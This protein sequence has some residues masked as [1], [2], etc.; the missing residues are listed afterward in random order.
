MS[1]SLDGV[2]LHSHGSRLMG[3]FFRAQA[4]EPRPTALLLHGIPGVEKNYDLA[5]ALRD[6][7]WNVLTFHYR[8][9]WGSEGEYTLPGIVDDIIVAIDYL[10]ERADVDKRR[11][12]GVGLSLGGWGVVMAAARDERLRA[13]VSLNPLVDP[14][15]APLSDT[16]AADFA[17]MLHGIT[18][19]KAQ[20]QWAMLTPL[21]RV[22]RQLAGRPTLLLTGDADELFPPAHIQ[23]L[24]DA[25]PF[26]EWKRI[27]GASHT[28]N[29]HRAVVVHT[30]IDWLTSVFSSLPLLPKGF[31]LRAARES[32]Y[33]RV[34]DVMAEW[35]GGRDLSHL[36][37]RLFFQHFN[38]TSFI[39]EQD[40]TLVAF[41]IGF[42]SQSE[43][44]VAYI[45][46]AG[47]HPEYRRAGLG[48]ALYERFFEK[49]RARGAREVH[50]VTAPVNA[51]SIAF[52]TKM[53]FVASEPI[54]DY[55]GR[56]GDRVSF[57]KMI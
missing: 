50:C 10:S 6:A 56:G 11:L 39:V 46:F 29:D 53:G 37:P 20:A 31:T 21:T 9:C 30:V 13:V 19:A 24:A 7:G 57:K 38:D 35:W 22:A 48:R 18:A 27:P 33:A 26:A 8:G 28:F 49:A 17:S 47:V 32:D 23:P 16:H 1:S 4:D 40:G 34:M 41:L 42:M 44:R 54:T 12:A 43:P 55:D 2:V 5:Y 51:G 14:H 36:L 45:H 52:H 3:A 25:M 15:T